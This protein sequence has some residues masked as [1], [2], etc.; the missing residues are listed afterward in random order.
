MSDYNKYSN[1]N[2]QPESMPKFTN[3]L[4][5]SSQ[6]QKDN[7]Q[8]NTVT[9][10]NE[11]RYISL[12]GLALTLLLALT[13][14]LQLGAAAIIRASAPQLFDLT[15]FIWLLSMAPLYLVAY[16]V[17]LLIMKKV[18]A[19]SPDSSPLTKSKL[20]MY[21]VMG[22]TLMY[23]GNL[24]G[25][26]INALLNHI[27]DLE[28]SSSIQDII[29]NSSLLSNFFFAVILAPLAEEYL[30]RK[31]L[32]DRTIRYG[33]GLAIM[34]SALFFGL[35]HGNF[36]QFFYAFGLGALFAFIYIKTGRLRYPIALHMLINFSGSI[37]AP[38][39]ISRLDLEALE[40][41]ADIPLDQLNPDELWPVIAPSLPA[42]F[43]FGIYIFI[44]LLLAFIGFILLI[45]K[46][47]SFRLHETTNLANKQE[48]F[49]S[50]WLN[51]FIV[52][53]IMGCMG[54][55]IYQLTGG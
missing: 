31:I 18:P 32:I 12:I 37:V 45:V 13:V 4:S 30:F 34:L 33:K 7:L 27:F 41:L 24:L 36:S 22:V 54:L 21:A 29:M 35:F 46:R 55:F 51:P 40:T 44:M 11:K 14:L 50:I 6:F 23:A 26:L 48:R 16:P 47:K 28:P 17:C 49:K 8:C 9:W 38:A 5:D 53:F 43:G 15:W 20:L 1:D 39:L 42:L 3:E 10:A 19:T 2:M 25:V 52:L